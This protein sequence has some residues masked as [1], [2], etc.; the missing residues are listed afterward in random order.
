MVNPRE[1]LLT[2]KFHRKSGL[3]LVHLFVNRN[4]IF[5]QFLFAQIKQTS[6]TNRFFVWEEKPEI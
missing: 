3:F 2:L 1:P 4:Q 6:G 5:K